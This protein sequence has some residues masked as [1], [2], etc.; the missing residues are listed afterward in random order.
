MANKVM[1]LEDNSDL[2]M[3]IK[4]MRVT[5]ETVIPVAIKLPEYLDVTSLLALEKRMIETVQLCGCRLRLVGK[6]KNVDVE[7]FATRIFATRDDIFL[8]VEW[9]E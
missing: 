5:K 9:S 4:R 8:S 3:H 7:K 6:T 2:I 1:M